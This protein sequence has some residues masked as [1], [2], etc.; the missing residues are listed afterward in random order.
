MPSA[1]VAPNQSPLGCSNVKKYLNKVACFKDERY[2]VSLLMVGETGSNPVPESFQRSRGLRRQ[3]QGLQHGQGDVPVQ[4]VSLLGQ[5]GR[6]SG[7]G[8]QL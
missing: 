4:R 5:P 8:G 2:I 6:G 1:P 3:A 7:L